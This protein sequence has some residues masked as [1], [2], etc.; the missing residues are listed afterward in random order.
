MK[1]LRTATVAVATAATMACAGTSFAAADEAAANQ[2][3][4]SQLGE[5]QQPAADQNDQAPQAPK[6]AEKQTEK[7]TKGGARPGDPTYFGGL[8]TKIGHQ[9]EADQEITG[10]E[11]FGSSEPEHTPRW[12]ELFRFGAASAFIAAVASVLNVFVPR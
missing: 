12:A 9:L 10:Y 2:P 5:A 11:F 1:K 4:A 8:F 3:A 7:K 6:T